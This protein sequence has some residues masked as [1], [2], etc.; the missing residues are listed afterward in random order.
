MTLEQ[1]VERRAELKERIELL[2]QEVTLIDER[3]REQGFGRFPVGEWDVNV[4]HNRRL[5]PA[6]IEAKYPV[7][8]Y[9]QFYKPVIST[10]AIK[11]HIAPAQL[12]A[13][14]VEGKARVVVK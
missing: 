6:L 12:E 11:E 2:T 5:D 13:F 3:I 8:Q 4:Q 14:Y 10:D 9:P 1:D 7:T